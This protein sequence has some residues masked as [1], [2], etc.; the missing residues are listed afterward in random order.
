MKKSSKTTVTE[1]MQSSTKFE[2]D[3]RHDRGVYNADSV[4]VTFNQGSSLYAY[5]NIFANISIDSQQTYI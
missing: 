3:R 1:P 4:R 2:R 5:E